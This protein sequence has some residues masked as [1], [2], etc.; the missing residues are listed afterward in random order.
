MMSKPRLRLI[1]C[2]DDIEPQVRDRRRERSFQLSV[3][4]GGRRAV[5]AERES[6]LEALF[7]LFDLAVL[8]A[9]ANC[10]AFIAASLTTLDPHG[11]TDPEQ[12]N[13]SRA[14]LPARKS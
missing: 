4:D 8:V 5:A 9:H 7:G 10:A 12:T 6:P 13:H 1:H 14:A 3:I 11:W 2:S